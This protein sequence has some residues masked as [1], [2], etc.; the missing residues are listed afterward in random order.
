MFDKMLYINLK[1]FSNW[2]GNICCGEYF[3]YI[4]QYLS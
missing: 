2:L 4:K 3:R 1:G